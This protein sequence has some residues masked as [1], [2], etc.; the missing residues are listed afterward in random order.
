MH[1]FT[2]VKSSADG[3]NYISQVKD[4]CG[5]GKVGRVRSLQ[6]MGKA[7][8]ALCLTARADLFTHVMFCILIKCNVLFVCAYILLKGKTNTPGNIT[9]QP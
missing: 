8:I 6:V 1:H 5:S 4:E 7:G 3:S 2:Y 9:K